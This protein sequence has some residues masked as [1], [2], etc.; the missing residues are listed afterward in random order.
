MIS[1]YS[2]TSVK[3]YIFSPFRDYIHSVLRWIESQPDALVFVILVV[4]YTLVSLPIAWGYIIINIAT[5]K[6]K[7]QSLQSGSITV[8]LI[9]CLFCFDSAA[10]LMLN[11]WIWI[12]TSQTGGHAECSWSLYHKCNCWLCKQIWLNFNIVLF[13]LHVRHRQRDSCHS[14]HSDAWNLFCPSHHEAVSRSI[15]SKVSR[16]KGL[17]SLTKES[18]ED[19]PICSKLCWK[20]ATPSSTS[21]IWAKNIWKLISMLWGF[22]LGLT[23]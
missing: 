22:E 4:L 15:H 8:R 23:K 14:G 12:Q 18:K 9:S 17:A 16:P 3:I 13:R 21:F 10:L 20:Y 6:M 19:G 1:Y 7:D 11:Y 2:D 5:G